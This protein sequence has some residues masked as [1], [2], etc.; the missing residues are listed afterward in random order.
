MMWKS[1]PL[2]ELGIIVGFIAT[3]GTLALFQLLMWRWMF[4]A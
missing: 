3:M 4:G 1:N 2:L